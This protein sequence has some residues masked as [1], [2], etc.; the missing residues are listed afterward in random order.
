MLLKPSLT[1]EKAKRKRMLGFKVGFKFYYCC[2]VLGNILLYFFSVVTKEN[3]LKT[4]VENSLFVY[5]SISSDYLL[6]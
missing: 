2:Y 1:S 5:F 4:K 6:G 3:V